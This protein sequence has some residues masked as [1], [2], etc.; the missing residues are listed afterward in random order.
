MKL[1]LTLALT[2][3]TAA[4]AFALSPGTGTTTSRST[5]SVHQPSF[6]KPSLLN[7][8]GIQH[9]G[10]NTAL[11]AAAATSDS[12]SDHPVHPSTAEMKTENPLPR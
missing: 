10:S 3:T 4:S 5:S 11:H 6:I 8:N 12:S 9:H 1:S 2:F 7:N